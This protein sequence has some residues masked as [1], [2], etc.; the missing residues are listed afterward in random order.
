LEVFYDCYSFSLGIKHTN[1][2]VLLLCPVINRGIYFRPDNFFIGA[3]LRLGVHN[4][5][6]FFSVPIGMAGI[7]STTT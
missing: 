5:T 1:L 6:H 7:L 2:L 4:D 3:S